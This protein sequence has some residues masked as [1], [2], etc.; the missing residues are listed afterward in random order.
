M[1][2]GSARSLWIRC[3]GR[4]LWPCSAVVA[5]RR[6]SGG[7]DDNPC[8]PHLPSLRVVQRPIPLPPRVKRTRYNSSA[9]CHFKGVSVRGTHDDPTWRVRGTAVEL[10]RMIEPTST[11]LEVVGPEGDVRT[12]TFDTHT[13]LVAFHA[14]FEQA[15]ARSGWTF[16]EFQPE[17]R[18]GSDR[19]AIP[20]HPDRRGSL[21]LVWSR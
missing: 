18:T 5:D 20:R 13:A 1:K 17:R 14:G 9:A 4:G 16:A 21:A 19:R 2:A 10:R 3:I 7:C 15:L 12:F 6:K 8:D 11:Q